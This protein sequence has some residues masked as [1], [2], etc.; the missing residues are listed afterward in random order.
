MP[1]LIG[2]DG[3]KSGDTQDWRL[4]CSGVVGIVRRYITSS[5]KGKT[6]QTERAA[7][8]RTP[9]AFSLTLGAHAV[10]GRADGAHY[11]ILLF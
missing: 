1:G 7:G 6:R 10:F 4:K 5:N 3:R 8:M 2:F 11:D 9:A